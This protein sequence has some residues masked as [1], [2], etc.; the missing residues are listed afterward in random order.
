M[1]SIPD[2]FMCPI[3]LEIMDDPVLC[4]DTYTY[5]RTAIIAIQNSISPMTRQSFD[6]SNLIPN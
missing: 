6:K 2:E 4:D 1:A 3:T 5:E